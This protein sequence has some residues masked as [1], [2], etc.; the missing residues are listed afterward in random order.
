[1]VRGLN[2]FKESFAEYS[3]QYVLIGGVACTLAMD[4]AGITFRATSD[5]DIVLIV[6]A[7]SN[8]FV[9]AFWDFI[10]AGE[11]DYKQKSTKKPQFYR[12]HSSR[13]ESYPKV[14]ELFSRKPDM[15]DLQEET[16][17]TPIPA[18]EDLSSLS[19]ILIDDEYYDFVRRGMV[20]IDGLSFVKADH[21]IPLK[22]RAWLDLSERR[23]AD[24]KIDSKDIKKHRNDVFRLFQVIEP[25][26]IIKLL[27][28]VKEDM[29]KGLALLLKEGSLDIKSLGIKKR[30]V[31]DVVELLM[32]KYGL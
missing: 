20:V 17:L 18:G 11:Y 31:K 10:R 28:T 6:G 15:L 22:I 7:Q 25:N 8:E 26:E 9:K 16:H 24:A 13:K 12:F 19:A 1:M 29:R 21:L 5:L 14:L 27:G 4:E 3:D 2:L 23:K 32:T 30:S